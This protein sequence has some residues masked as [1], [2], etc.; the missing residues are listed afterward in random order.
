MSSSL[1]I[2]DKVVLTLFYIV[3]GMQSQRGKMYPT[4]LAI[5][6]FEIIWNAKD[7]NDEFNNPEKT[8]TIRFNQIVKSF[9]PQMNLENS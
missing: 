4:L 3:Y 9:H 2:Y 1:L 6:W 7:Q 8:R 5:L